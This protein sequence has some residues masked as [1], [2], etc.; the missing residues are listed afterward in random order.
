MI[1]AMLT[2]LNKS[3]PVVASGI[4]ILAALLG[5][6][7]PRITV[8][9]PQGSV[10]MGS[11]ATEPVPTVMAKSIQFS[12]E[13][14]G[15]DAPPVINL[16]RG[17]PPE[18]YGAVIRRLGEGVPMTDPSQ[19]AFHIESVRISGT[20]A[21]VDMIHPGTIGEYQSVTIYLDDALF[22]GWQVNNSRPWRFRVT[23]PAPHYVARPPKTEPAPPP[24]GTPSEPS[25]EPPAS[26]PQSHPHPTQD[27]TAPAQPSTATARTPAVVVPSSPRT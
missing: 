13:W 12:N 9:A 5:A 14:Y 21:E 16:P 1:V 18:V 8:P 4:L 27:H 23:P 10:S 24:A 3:R 22:R 11:I 15:T 17:T 19:R 20:T 26:Q 25:N 2:L 7:T 6:C